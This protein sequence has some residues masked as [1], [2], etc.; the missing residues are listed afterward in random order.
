MT[1]GMHNFGIFFARF[2]PGFSIASR[3]NFPPILRM[4]LAQK[5]SRRSTPM[6]MQLFAKTQPSSQH[7][8]RRIGKPKPRNMQPLASPSSSVRPKSRLR[9]RH[10]KPVVEVLR[11]RTGMRTR[12][13]M[14]NNLLLLSHE[15]IVSYALSCFAGSCPLGVFVSAYP[16]PQKSMLCFRILPTIR[17]TLQVT[18]GS[19]SGLI[20]LPMIVL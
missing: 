20:T 1:S 17:D 3:S 18:C 9:L 10:S 13:R 11:T 4:A 19:R 7:R 6:P 8:R 16:G 5:I 14:K 2:L 12:T 15:D